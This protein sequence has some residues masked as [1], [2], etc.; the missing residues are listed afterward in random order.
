VEGRIGLAQLAELGARTLATSAEAIA[1]VAELVQRTT[2]VDFTVVSEITADGSYVFRGVE[3]FAGGPV[4]RDSAIPYEW[5][6]CSRIHVGESPADVPDT[7]EVP[8]LWQQW[9][10]L[11]AGIGV[12]WDVLA[13]CTREVRLPDGS[14]YGTLCLHN[15]RPRRFSEDETALLEVLARLLGQELWR[16]RAAGELADAVAAL[17]EA[18]RRRVELAEELQH[19]LRAP[20]QVLDGYAEAMLDGVV[21]RDDDHLILVRREAGRAMQLLDDLA[22]LARLETRLGGEEREPVAA[23]EVVAEMR[24]RL[25]PLAESAGVELVAEVEPATLLLPRKR[26]EQ[27]YVNLV[28]NALRAVQQGGGSRIVMFVRAEGA[29]AAVGVEDD[30]PGIAPE[31]APRVFERFYR[32]S[33]GRAA[34][35]GSGLGL[36]IARRIAEAAGG[37]LALEAVAPYGVRLVARLPLAPQPVPGG[38]EAAVEA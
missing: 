11:K 26:L 38:D 27:L 30:G 29:G 34:G 32:G 28:R 6:L 7:R 15:R 18:E 9:L 2:G 35:G 24:D 23:G 33:S 22:E 20:L 5:S 25:A 1:A 37:E 14:L 13:F 3:Q 19:E 12:D 21:G 17:D 36:T 16:E 31:E 8:A 4:V 10:R